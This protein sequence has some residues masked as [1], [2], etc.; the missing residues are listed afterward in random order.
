MPDGLPD[1]IVRDSRYN[2]RKVVLVDDVKCQ[3]NPD[4]IELARAPSSVKLRHIWFDYHKKCKS[5]VG[6]LKDIFSHVF[7]DTKIGPKDYFLMKNGKIRQI[8]QRI[9]RTNCIDCLDRTNVVQTFISRVVLNRQLQEMGAKLSEEPNIMALNDKVCF[10]HEFW[11]NF[12]CMSIE[13]GDS[14]SI[15]VG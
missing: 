2:D 12:T 10:Y 7:P 14:L 15:I 11:M 9:T 1:R 3:L 4:D 8:Q 6:T 5:D 13:F